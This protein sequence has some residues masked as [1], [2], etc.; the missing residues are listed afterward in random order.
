M[1][2][3]SISI[4]REKDNKL[5][6]GQARLKELRNAPDRVMSSVIKKKYL[7]I[8]NLAFKKTETNYEWTAFAIPELLKLEILG[9]EDKEQYLSLLKIAF[10]EP[11]NDFY[12][13]LRVVPELLK[14]GILEKDEL[15][16]PYLSFLKLAFQK[17]QTDF[18]WAE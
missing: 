1:V 5:S 16:E 13:S 9:R 6:Q 12:W 15:K 17:A 8:L 10:E 14:L 18:E 4:D 2:S 7:N 3:N 11:Q